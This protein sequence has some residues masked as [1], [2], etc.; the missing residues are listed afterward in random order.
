[1][2]GGWLKGL[3]RMKIIMNKSHYSANFARLKDAGNRDV[4]TMVIMHDV[5]GISAEYRKDLY[6]AVAICFLVGAFL[7][8][9]LNIFFGRMEKKLGKLRRKNELILQYFIVIRRGYDF[10]VRKNKWLSVKGKSAE[11]L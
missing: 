3:K 5:T 7:L 8:L 6:F 10:C 2:R 1:M 11:I 4:G 9:A